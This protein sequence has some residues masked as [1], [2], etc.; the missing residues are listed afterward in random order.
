MILAGAVIAGRV[1]VAVD[2]DTVLVSER[3]SLDGLAS[4]LLGLT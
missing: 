2:A 4:E 1:M 3:D